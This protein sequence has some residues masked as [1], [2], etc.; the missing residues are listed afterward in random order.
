MSIKD[1]KTAI[2]TEM[3]QNKEFYNDHEEFISNYNKY[4]DRNILLEILNEFHENEIVDCKHVNVLGEPY[5]FL[6]IKLSIRGMQYVEQLQSNSKDDKKLKTIIFKL[7]IAL[8]SSILGVIVQ[9]II[10]IKMGV[11]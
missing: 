5:Y 11:K 9:K 3:Y 2:L 8:G 6:D 4:G 10:E 7:I 1:I